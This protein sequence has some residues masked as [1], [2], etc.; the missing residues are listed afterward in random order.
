MNAPWC[1][2]AGWA[3]DLF[4]GGT[5]REHDDVEI[6]VPRGRFGEIVDALP[7][8]EWDTIGDGRAWTYPER[9][10]ETHQTWLR[11]PASVI[12]RLDVFREPHDGD[13]WI[14]RR[15]ASIVLPYRE[16]IRHTAD[17]IP[18]AIP[19]VVLLFKAKIMRPKDERD[20]ARV[21]PLLDEPRRQRLA[22]WLER[23]HPG[24]AWTEQLAG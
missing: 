17:G 19:E 11:E 1:V 10:A 16:L 3:I 7:G 12:Y 2:V 21:L 15:D 20:F 13:R 24:H 23:V 9:A 5:P 4:A 6:A 14:C 8:F 18:Y 22:W